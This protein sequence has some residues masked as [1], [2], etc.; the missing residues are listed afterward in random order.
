V[1]LDEINEYA[2]RLE[3][4]GVEVVRRHYVDQ[5]HGFITLIGVLPRAVESAQYI[6]DQLQ[7]YLK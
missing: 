7:T 3:Q 1:L 6:A 2:D 5:M 4:E